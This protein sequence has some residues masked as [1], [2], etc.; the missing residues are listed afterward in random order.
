M[1]INVAEAKAEYVAGTARKAGKLVSKFIAASGIIAKMTAP[2]A[3]TRFTTNVVSPTAVAQRTKKLNALG[4]AGL[5]AAMQR[6]G[7]SNY[8]TGTA[9]AQD[10]WATEF[11]PYATKLD[12]IVAGLP[13]RGTTAAENV[14]NRCMPIATGLES[15]KKTR[16]GVS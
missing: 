5:K 12:S 3:I 9:A 7:Q 14:T 4:D 8:V 10:K 11:S 1:P 13:A 6:K 16:L 15:E 2:D